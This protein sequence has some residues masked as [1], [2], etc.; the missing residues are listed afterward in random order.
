MIIKEKKV[1]TPNA[2]TDLLVSCTLALIKKKSHLT[3]N[4]I[5]Y[6]GGVLDLDIFYLIYIG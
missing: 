1:F 3:I 6:M 4:I 5:F 2:T